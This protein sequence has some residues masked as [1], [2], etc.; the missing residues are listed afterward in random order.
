MAGCGGDVNSACVGFRGDCADI[1][2]QLSDLYPLLASH[3]CDGFPRPDVLQDRLLSGLLMAAIGF[4]TKFLLEAIF[5]GSNETEQPRR[6]L[7]FAGLPKLF[8]GRANW[9][10]H[11]VPKWLG[12]GDVRHTLSRLGYLRRLYARYPGAHRAMYFRLIRDALHA[13]MHLCDAAPVEKETPAAAQRRRGRAASGGDTRTQPARR[14]PSKQPAPSNE[15][16][17]ATPSATGGRALRAVRSIR[18]VA[19]TVAAVVTASK[20]AKSGGGKAV[21]NGGPG[22]GATAARRGLQASSPGPPDDKYRPSAIRSPQKRESQ[23]G[24]SSSAKPP[25]DIGGNPS[26]SEGSLHPGKYGQRSA[27][28]GSG[29]ATLNGAAVPT[30]AAAR[31]KGKSSAAEEPRAATSPADAGLEA[32]E[33]PVAASEIPAT[34]RRV[35]KV[36]K[37]IKIVKRVK[38]KKQPGTLLAGPVAEGVLDGSGS[39]LS[40][41]EDKGGEAST[42]SLDQVA[43]PLSASSAGDSGS[44]RILESAPLTTAAGAGTLQRAMLRVGAFRIPFRRRAAGARGSAATEDSGQTAVSAQEA[45]AEKAFVEKALREG[46]KDTEEIQEAFAQQKRQAREQYISQLVRESE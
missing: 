34:G 38:V 19:A 11:D 30:R 20:A 2:R 24:E 31:R 8:T 4:P 17:S 40:P 23:Q 37:S 26:A 32:G 39:R 44:A 41:P 10:Y 9:A 25:F 16:T 43:V 21:S 22:G 15:A 27:G 6:W 14:R 1:P 36:V 45:A 28:G 35:L 5:V 12:Y 3:K 18:V 46:G 7:Q 42:A 13:L 33:P 29:A